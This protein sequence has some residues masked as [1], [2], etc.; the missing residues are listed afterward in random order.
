MYRLKDLPVSERPRERL[1]KVGASSLSDSELLA[2]ILS[3]GGRDKGILHLAQEILQRFGSLKGLFEVEMEEL[4][5]ISGIGPAKATVLKAVCE[6]SLRLN[7]DFGEP[8][9]PI[10]NPEQVFRIT[11][12]LLF[13]KKKEIVVLVLLDSRARVLSVEKFSVGTVSSAVLDP[14]DIFGL[15][16]RKNAS[17]VI[18]VHNHP[19]GDTTPSQE[20]VAA[21]QEIASAANLIGIPLVDHV[22][23]SDSEFVSLKALGLLSGKVRG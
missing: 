15:A 11:R 18:L 10:T 2:V 6:V 16:L 13:A 21:T 19:S 7:R 23:V 12:E 8:G 17:S 14:K 3:S 9:D 20:D 5:S 4:T 22:I 1:V